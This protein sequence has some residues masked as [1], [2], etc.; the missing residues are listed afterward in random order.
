[1]PKREGSNS[2]SS[3]EKHDP[4]ITARNA[5]RLYDYAHEVFAT[6][7][8][9]KAARILAILGDFKDGWIA[10]ATNDQ[11]EQLKLVEE[12]HHNPELEE[13]AGHNDYDDGIEIY[14]VD[15]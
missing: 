2:E 1:M 8:S 6:D 9:E 7:T 4:S 5:A 10:H 14:D 13:E 12:A 3:Q 11:E 15:K